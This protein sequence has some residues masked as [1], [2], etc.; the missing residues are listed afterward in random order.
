MIEDQNKYVTLKEEKGGKVRF[1]DNG[2]QKSLEEAR[3]VLT[4]V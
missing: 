4:M 2:S 3:Y 1:G